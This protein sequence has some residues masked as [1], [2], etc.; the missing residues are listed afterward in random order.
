MGR[1]LCLTDVN[2]W[3]SHTDRG[4]TGCHMNSALISKNTLK[5]STLFIEPSI[6]LSVFLS[7]ILSV[8][9]MLHYSSICCSKNS[10]AVSM[11]PQKISLLCLFLNCLRSIKF[12]FLLTKKYIFVLSTCHNICLVELCWSATFYF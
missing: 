11:M 9:V 4:A 1:K 2:V 10:Y 8:S 5:L 3:V 7:V 6:C 12:E